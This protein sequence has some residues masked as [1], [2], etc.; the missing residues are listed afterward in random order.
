M[1]DGHTE[2]NGKPPAVEACRPP[3]AAMFPEPGRTCS[4][5]PTFPQHRFYST[6]EGIWGRG[7]KNKHG[8]VNICC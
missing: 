6:T 4:T 8:L 1:G 5:G 7:L 2:L 3:S